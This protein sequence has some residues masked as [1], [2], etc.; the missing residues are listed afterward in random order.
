MLASLCWRIMRAEN[1]S[2]HT[3]QRMPPILFAA[4]MIPCPVPHSTIPNRQSPD[5]T[6]RAAASPCAG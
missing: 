2:A 4:I 6:R 5:A 1:V 3:P